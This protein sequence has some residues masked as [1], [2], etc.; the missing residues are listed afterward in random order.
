[1][2]LENGARMLATIHP[3]Y[4]LRVPDEAD[5][6]ALYAGFVADLK[7]CERALVRAA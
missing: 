2:P 3:S 6:H 7:T 1:M 5:R 4:I